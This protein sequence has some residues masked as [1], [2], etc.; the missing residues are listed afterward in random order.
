MLGDKYNVN[1]TFII[2]AW[3]IYS[4]PQGTL[5]S[6]MYRNHK[7]FDVKLSMVWLRYENHIAY[8]CVI[9]VQNQY[10]N[11]PH[12]IIIL[13]S[14]SFVKLTNVWFLWW[15]FYVFYFYYGCFYSV[16]LQTGWSVHTYQTERQ[17]K[18]QVLEKQELDIILSVIHR[19]EQLDQLEQHRIGY[20][21]T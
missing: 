13:K 14:M 21:R 9:I 15:Y 8:C 19:A 20:D 16:R 10:I 12:G 17:R 4:T 7:Q 6:K 5:R 3:N 1:V 2:I 11:L 18:S